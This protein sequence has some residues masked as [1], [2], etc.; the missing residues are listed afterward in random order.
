[1]LKITLLGLGSFICAFCS[2]A[3]AEGNCPPGQFPI[4]GQ[5]AI[6][7]APMPQSGSAMPQEPRP[8]GKWI[9]TWGAIALGTIDSTPYYGVPTGALSESEAKQQSLER[10]AKLGANN[11]R[12]TLTYQNQCAAI[13][14]PQVDGKPN[15]DGLVQ[16]TGRSTKAKASEDALH[17]C[18]KRNPGMQCKVIYQECSEPIFK[19]Y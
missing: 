13:G 1:M 15:P 9:K 12:V 8:L 6:S 14:E 2:H 17:Q 11:C 19:K 7:C 10:C 16:F 5:G 3:A 18:E 4:G